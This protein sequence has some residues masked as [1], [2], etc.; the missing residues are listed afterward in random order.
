MCFRNSHMAFILGCISNTR[1]NTGRRILLWYRLFPTALKLQ[2]G[3]DTDSEHSS[4]NV[5]YHRWYYVF[6][7]LFFLST[8]TNLGSGHHS[9]L[10]HFLDFQFR[11][12]SQLPHAWCSTI[13]F[14][15]KYITSQNHNLLLCGGNTETFLLCCSIFLVEIIEF[16]IDLKLRRLTVYLI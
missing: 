9:L 4:D 5:P 14:L 12:L 11:I 1:T 15:Y 8:L 3:L 10:S 6:L 16:H 2:W 7:T 13:N